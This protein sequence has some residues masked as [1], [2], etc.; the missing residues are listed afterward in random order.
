M[1]SDLDYVAVAVGRGCAPLHIE[2]WVEEQIAKNKEES[3]KGRV[4]ISVPK[5]RIIRNSI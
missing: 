1:P 5:L 4:K 3:A 2:E